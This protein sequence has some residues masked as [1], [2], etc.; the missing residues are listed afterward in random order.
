MCEISN[1]TSE[2]RIEPFSDLCL[3]EP[4]FEFDSSCA[5][6][7]PFDDAT[8]RE[9]FNE[10]LP[11]P[12]KFSRSES[13]SIASQTSW[14]RGALVSLLKPHKILSVAPD[15]LKMTE[16]NCD[17][18][19]GRSINV[20]F[21]P[22][23]DAESLNAAIKKAAHG[24]SSTIYT[25]LS[26]SK[27]S[28]LHVTTT[29]SPYHRLSDKGLDR[30]PAVCLL[31]IDCIHIPHMKPSEPVFILDE[32]GLISDSP[33]SSHSTTDPIGCRHSHLAK[34][35]GIQLTSSSSTSPQ[36]SPRNQL[37]RRLRLQANL[38]AGRDNEE[39]RRRQQQ[40]SCCRLLHDSYDAAGRIAGE[41]MTSCPASES[42]AGV[43]DP[44]LRLK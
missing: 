27:G 38:A 31:Q 6:E 2:K 21:G 24:Q 18:I 3:A 20:L 41:R 30:C 25:V 4:C 11:P 10:L 44:G 39:E 15:I 34:V 23:T 26:T 29:L 22:S 12:S 37:R 19:T 32:F 28:D 35:H 13:V 8:F 33:L 40:G 16:F 7:D 17:Q 36:P 14:C 42:S 1:S 43:K 9:S 5:S